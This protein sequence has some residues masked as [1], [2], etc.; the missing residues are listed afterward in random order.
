LTAVDLGN[1]ISTAI[2]SLDGPV[3]QVLAR[4]TSM[5]SGREIHRLCGA[6][7]VAGV[8]LVLQR[9]TSTGLVQVH[10]A[11]NSL[12]YALNRRHVAAPAVELL[13]DLRTT[14]VAGLSAKISTWPI[15]PVHASLFGAIAQGDGDLGSDVDLLLIRPEE[16]ASDNL[17]WEEQ[18]A[19]L[20][21]YIVDQ[22]GNPAQLYDLTRA[23]LATPDPAADD[24]RTHT[25]PLHGPTLAA[26]DRPFALSGIRAHS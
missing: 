24:W 23:E 26:L 11:G 6:G 9:L 5:L 8:R 15:P 13:A 22:T 3:L 7:S 17:L 10:E 12:L 21:Q 14:F 16:V 19:D 1:P 2:P 20:L 18:T 4:S 25:I